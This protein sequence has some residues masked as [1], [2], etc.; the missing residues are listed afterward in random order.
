MAFFVLFEVCR[1]NW[2]LSELVWVWAG[3]VLDCLFTE[4]VSREMKLEEVG[5]LC[6]YVMGLLLYDLVLG[7]NLFHRIGEGGNDDN[8][9]A[10]R[11]TLVADVEDNVGF[12]LCL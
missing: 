7:S 11:D 3:F 5:K 6:G 10:K 9:V 1:D 12:G 2:K 4:A 8:E